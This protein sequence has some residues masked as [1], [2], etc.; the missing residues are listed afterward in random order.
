MPLRYVAALTNPSASAIDLR[1]CPTYRE[2][3]VSTAGKLDRDYVLDCA[4]VAAIGP[5]E[6]VR[7]AMMFDIPRYQSPIDSA[8]LVWELDPYYSDGF[9]PRSPA[10]KVAIR[11]VAR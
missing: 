10:Q 8:A 3:L 7:F 5:G 2:S 11:I 9:A 4:T 1:P 6:T